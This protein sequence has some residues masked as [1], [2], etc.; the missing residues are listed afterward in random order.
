MNVLHFTKADIFY[1]SLI[2]IEITIDQ[3]DAFQMW[4]LKDNDLYQFRRYHMIDSNSLQQSKFVKGI[5]FLEYSVTPDLT[6]ANLPL[7]FP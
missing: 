7:L 6:A 5:V 3:I 2:Q 1:L 4:Y